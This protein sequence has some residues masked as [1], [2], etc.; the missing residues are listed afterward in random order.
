MILT[1][2]RSLFYLSTF[3]S[4]F[5]VKYTKFCAFNLNSILFF[6]NGSLQRERFN[7]ND[8]NSILTGSY[9]NLLIKYCPVPVFIF[10]QCFLNF[11]LAPRD[12]RIYGSVRTA[13]RPF[14]SHGNFGRVQQAGRSDRRRPQKIL[15]QT[16]KTKTG[17][18]Q[19][20]LHYITFP[21]FY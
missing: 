10:C 5:V 13:K 6:L 8:G 21:L 9:K 17:G 7:T 16:A 19:K 14:G 3:G 4:F 11:K 18:H 20:T 1:P 15:V 12:S 2:V